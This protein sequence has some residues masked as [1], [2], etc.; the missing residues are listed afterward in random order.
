MHYPQRARIIPARAGFTSN[1]RPP[2]WGPGDHPRSR[3]VY[4]DLTLPAKRGTGSSPLARGLQSPWHSSHCRSRIIP[5]RAGF[6]L[7]ITYV[8]PMWS[9]HPRS[10]GV[11]AAGAMIVGS[12]AGSSPLAR[13]LQRLFPRGPSRPGIIPA[14]AGFTITHPNPRHS[15]ADHPRSRGVYTHPPHNLPPGN[16]SSP[17][18]RG[19]PISSGVSKY[20]VGIIPARAGFTSP[21]I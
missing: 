16:G 14:R 2:G 4:Q 13:G 6:T 3:G 11:Y 12:I 1:P 5:A 18:A 9:D 10:R 21:H 19:L 20:I 8:T 17:L 15:S 7:F